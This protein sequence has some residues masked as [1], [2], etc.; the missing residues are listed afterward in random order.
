M[1]LA[2]VQYRTFGWS[3]IFDKRERIQYVLQDKDTPFVYDETNFNLFGHKYTLVTGIFRRKVNTKFQPK[4]FFTIFNPAIE[5]EFNGIP[6]SRNS[7]KLDW[8]QRGRGQGVSFRGCFITLSIVGK[9]IFCIS[10]RPIL[11]T[12]SQNER[13]PSTSARVSNV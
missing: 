11:V 2:G 9:I 1:H 10:G 3:I 12:Y 5:F 4:R 13:F 8:N 7:Q 6:C